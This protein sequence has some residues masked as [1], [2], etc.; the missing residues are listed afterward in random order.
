MESS[1]TASR[2]CDNRSQRIGRVRWVYTGAGIDHHGIEPQP[3]GLRAADPIGELVGDLLANLLHA[4]ESVV[5]RP[6]RVKLIGMVSSCR[7]LPLF[8]STVLFLAFSLNVASSAQRLKTGAKIQPASGNS[9]ARDCLS[10]ADLLKQA[11]TTDRWMEIDLYWFKQKDLK[12]SVREFWDRFQPLYAG[13]SGYRGVILNI[14]WTVGPVMEWSGKLDQRISLPTGSG[15]SRWVDQSTPLTGTTAERKQKSEARYAGSVV[16][17]RRGYDPWTYGDVK[18]LIADLKR[19][20][21][22]RGISGFK[23]GM[24]NYAW[25]D[26]Y[27]EEAAWVSRHPEAFTKPTPSLPL[28]QE[29]T[30]YFDPAAPLHA[31]PIPLG[32]LPEGIA[33][34]MP[35][36]RAYAAQ[37]GS[38]SR[39]LSLDAIM[40]RDS[41]GMPVPY[42]RGGPWGPVAPSAEI[43]HQVTDA[44]ATLVKET[45]LANPHALVMMYS[46]AASAVA[47]WPS[48]GLD[49]EAIAKQGYLDIWVD[50]TWAGAWN[51]VGIRYKNFWNNPTLGWT[52]QLDYMLAHAAILADTKVRHYPLVETFD[53]WESWDVIHSAPQRLRWGI[54]A[55]SHAA[56]KTP[57]GLKLP[58]GSYISWANQGDRLLSEADVN[59]LASNIN[60][61]VAD[62]HNTTAVFGPTLVYSRPAMQWQI[63][64]ASPGQDANEW[65]DEQMGSLAKWPVPILSATRLEWLPRVQS[66]LFLIQTPSHLSASRLN[67][68]AR[69]IKSG[70]PVALI[71]NFTGSIDDSLLRLAGLRESSTPVEKPI[72]LCKAT[73]QA[74][75][76]AKNIP[77]TFNTYCRPEIGTTVAGATVIYTEEGSPALTLDATGGR[78]AAA[79]NAPDL[80]SLQEIPLSQ[81]WGNTG[82]PYALATGTLNVMLRRNASLHA[83]QI[84]LNQTMSIAAWRTRNGARHLLGGNLEE[85]LRDDADLLRH[86][87]IVIPKSWHSENWKDAWTGQKFSL[88]DDRLLVD[89]PQASS[90][91]LESSR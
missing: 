63:D 67:T 81:I 31:D 17:T 39:A 53:A 23:V 29:P 56:V 90:V 4:S 15:Q 82:A 84:D 36:H 1:Y 48:N 32:G 30:R 65:L 64:H 57:N 91:L 35:V 70:Q 59:F 72:Q 52:Y 50:Q 89:L 19:E 22:R 66:D 25:T 79:W 28:D 7:L 61:A 68:L 41:F 83:S 87:T 55:Y 38:I 46:N 45:K 54:W 11:A 16:S 76:L 20:A 6:F 49:L 73:T 14:G 24:L 43:V 75:D 18:Q 5:C 86:S 58:V 71:G 60:A 27:G 62:A 21:A 40:L 8:F 10:Q 34:G 78:L 77:P 9:I 44:V 26:A 80:R 47:D 69:L 12:K 33:E 51:E 37:W 88:D 3:L 13:V 85:G 42:E 74:S 2:H